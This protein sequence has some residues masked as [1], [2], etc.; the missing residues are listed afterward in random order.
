MNYLHFFFFFRAAVAAYGG[1]QVKARL[2]A[3][4][5]SLCHSYSNA[6]SEPYLQPTPEPTAT[7][8]S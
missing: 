6:R 3:A 8:D 4:A 5:A 7:L 1:S 2:R